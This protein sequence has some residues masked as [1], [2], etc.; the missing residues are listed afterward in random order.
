MEIRYIY[1]LKRR[2]REILSTMSSR[3]YKRYQLSDSDF[4][5]W[6]ELYREKPQTYH[7]LVNDLMNI[8]NT[9][10]PIKSIAV[11]PITLV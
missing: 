7:Y 11:V 4:T 3:F 8:V 6:L 9:H 5:E 10:V 1:D 2:T